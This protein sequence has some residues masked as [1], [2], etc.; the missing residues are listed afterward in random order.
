MDM[1]PMRAP[2]GIGMKGS[3]RVICPMAQG[4]L[5]ILMAVD[6][7]VSS[8]TI[9][10]MGKVFSSMLMGRYLRESFLGAKFMGIVWPG[11]TMGRSMRASGLGGSSRAMGSIF[12]L[13]GR[14]MKGSILG[15]LGMGLEPC[16]IRMGRGILGS[17]KKDL[18]ME[19]ESMNLKLKKYMVYGSKEISLK[20]K[21][22]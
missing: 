2:M 12:G 4:R 5:T 19:K 22:D 10:N 11:R 8:S 17:G 6:M 9:G 18:S 21:N 15:I 16:T 7:W 20:S 14:G 3:G 1:E 13:M